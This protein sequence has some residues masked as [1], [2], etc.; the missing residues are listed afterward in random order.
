MPEQRRERRA[1]PAAARS[2]FAPPRTP[3]RRTALATSDPPWPYVVV[4]RNVI[5]TPMVQVCDSL[6]EARH[7]RTT[8]SSPIYGLPDAHPTIY[9]VHD[10]EL[11]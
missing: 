7:W 9:E 6:D 1:H 5:G 4:Y 3:T 2:S 10:S 8:L 11:P